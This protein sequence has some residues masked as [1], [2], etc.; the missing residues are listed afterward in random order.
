MPLPRQRLEGEEAG[1]VG[2]GRGLIRTSYDLNLCDI[3]DVESGG[4][5]AEACVRATEIPRARAE[6]GSAMQTEQAHNVERGSLSRCGGGGM[7]MGSIRLSYGRTCLWVGSAASRGCQ[8]RGKVEGIAL[9]AAPLMTVDISR[10]FTI[11]RRVY[12]FPIISM[13]NERHLRAFAS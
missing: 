2:W 4:G 5:R 1:E 9:L 11:M 12:I 7:G 3:C 13:E 6:V 8:E 10:S